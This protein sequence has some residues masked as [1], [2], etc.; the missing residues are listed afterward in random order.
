MA[1]SD[2]DGVFHPEQAG[3]L[4]DRMEELS[5]KLE[6]LESKRWAESCKQFVSGRSAAVTAGE[7]LE[8]HFK[9]ATPRAP[10]RRRP[11][12]SRTEHWRDPPAHR[13][14][15]RGALPRR[16]L[17]SV[18]SPAGTYPAETIRD[19]NLRTSGRKNHR[20]AAPT[21]SRAP[22]D[23]TE[24]GNRARR[25]R[26]RAFAPQR[27]LEPGMIPD[28]HTGRRPA[29]SDFGNRQ[30]GGA[31]PAQWIH[32]GFARKDLRRHHRNHR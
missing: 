4:A 25:A 26:Q 30:R 2:C 29:R 13:L 10:A 5:P 15:T 20:P 18:G 8:F 21:T 7:D 11:R 3:P 31:G 32:G 14:P 16:D 6:L 22:A 27:R 9:K 17:D 24:E 1:P 23:A 28:R 19:V 12:L